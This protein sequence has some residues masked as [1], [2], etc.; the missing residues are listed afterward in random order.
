MAI[1]LHIPM[2]NKDAILYQGYTYIMT[3][4]NQW[5]VEKR[6]RKSRPEV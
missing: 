5:Y 4:L 1:K 6:N 2:S 3:V